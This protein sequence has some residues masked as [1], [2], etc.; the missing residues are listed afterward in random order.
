MEFLDLLRVESS[1]IRLKESLL[2][3]LILLKFMI[4][5]IQPIVSTRLVQW[6]VANWIERV[7]SLKIMF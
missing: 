1:I 5:I 4:I 2:D 3:K 6:I 7:R